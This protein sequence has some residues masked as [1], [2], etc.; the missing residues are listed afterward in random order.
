MAHE[1]T[2]RQMPPHVREALIEALASALVAD[3][4]ER[5]GLIFSGREQ[6]DDDADDLMTEDIE[7]PSSHN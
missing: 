3:W 6:D 5:P 2:P 1:Q 7:C 4:L